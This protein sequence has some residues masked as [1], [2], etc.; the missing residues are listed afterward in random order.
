MNWKKIGSFA[1]V[2]ILIPITLGIGV[3]LFK[4]RKYNIISIA[5]A[6]LACVPNLLFFE[7]GK[8]DTRRMVV[9]AVMVAIASVG[10]VLFAPI[11]SFKPVTAIVVVTGIYLGSEAGFFTG[12][13]TAVISNMFFGQGP[14]TPFQMFSW[15]ILGF[16][17]GLPLL[18]NILKASVQGK[19]SVSRVPIV[20][21]GAAAGVLY[22]MLMDVWSTLNLD[23]TFNLL[24]YLVLLGT[25][26]PTT[27]IYIVSNIVFLLI[28]AKPIGTR[29][30]RIK[31]KYG[32]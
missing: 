24:R 21:Y 9:I 10:R 19:K 11:P 3:V 6:L 2:I 27:V 18:Q 26:I 14:W 30:E 13:L 16:I 25:G 29:I 31:I 23:G 22:S 20:V 5:V 32:I 12:A 7:K 17:A 4:G 1:I 8:A 15:G 28:A